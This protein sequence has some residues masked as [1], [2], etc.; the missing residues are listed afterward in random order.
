MARTRQLAEQ[1]ARQ[2][3]VTRVEDA[4]LEQLEKSIA[5]VLDELTK[6]GRRARR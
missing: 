1:Q 4:T 3:G 6:S 2:V 5:L